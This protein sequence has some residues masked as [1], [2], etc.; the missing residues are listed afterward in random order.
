M[1]RFYEINI[2]DP[3]LV[4]LL[5]KVANDVRLSF[6]DG[7]LLDRTFDFHSVMQLADRFRERKV[8]KKASYIVNAHLNYTNVCVSGCKFCAYWKARD[9]SDAITLS[10][11]EAVRRIPPGIDEIHIVGGVN[12]DLDL[13]YH[14]DLLTAL[15]KAFPKAVLKAFTAV[16][17][18]ALAGREKLTVEDIL[19]ELINAGLGMIPGGGAE[20]FNEKIRKEICPVKSTSEEWLDVH[21]AAHGLGLR[22]NSTM[23]HGHIEGSG[24]RID[25][26]LRL[27]KLQDETGGFVAHIPLPYLH[28]SNELAERTYA[29]SGLM[30][31]RQVAVAR[32]MLDNVTNIKA[33]WRVFGVKL[34]QVCLRAGANDLDGTVSREDIMHEAGSDAPR[35]LTPQVME[36]LIRDAGF[37]PFRRDS[38][39]APIDAKTD[40]LLQAERGGSK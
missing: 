13:K 32:L 31:V 1:S 33:Y 37:E 25:H 4:P 5:D 2:S 27:R 16:E 30:D 35:S 14:L 20:I 21:R 22:S 7:M 23:L 36:K 29:L 26:L 38:F 6:D 24:D 17:I 3:R 11:E 9:A 28:G 19:K 18:H 34:A 10:P 40:Y 39:H 12:P 15:R 8:G